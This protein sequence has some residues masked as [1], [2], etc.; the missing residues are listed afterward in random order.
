VVFYS[1]LFVQLPEGVLSLPIKSDDD[2]TMQSPF[3]REYKRLQ[4]HEDY[5]PSTSPTRKQSPFDFKKGA[6]VPVSTI[7]ELRSAVLDQ[8][9]ELRQVQIERFAQEQTLPIQNHDVLQLMAQRFQNH[10][11]PS[12]RG[13]DTATLALAMEGGGMR[14]CVSAGMAA[15]IASLGLTDT[16]DVIYGASAGSV[17]GSYMVSRQM[18]MDVYVD[19]LPAA[20]KLFVCKQRMFQ[21]LAASLVDVLVS[22]RTKGKSSPPPGMNISY[23]LDGIMGQDHGIRPL[24]L[25]KFEQNNAKQPLRVVSSCIDAKGHLFSKCFGTS[26]FDDATTTVVAG[27][28]P[29]QGLFACL[30]AGMTVPGATGAPVDFVN[31]TTREPYSCFDAFCF[32]PIPYR[33]AVQEGATHVLVLCSR[34][35]GFQPKTKPGVY[36]QGVAPLYFY[37]HGHDKV[38]QFFEQGGQQYVYAEDLLLLE[39]GKTNQRVLVPPPEILYGIPRTEKMQ[40]SIDKRHQDWSQA[41]LL[42]LKVPLGTPELDVLEQDKDAVLH[43][44]R[45]GF[46]VAFD[47][48]APIVGL[49][50][51]AITGDQVAQLVFPDDDADEDDPMVSLL[52]TKVHVPGETISEAPMPVRKLTTTSFGLDASKKEQLSHTLLTSLPGFQD[53][54]FGHLAKGLRYGSNSLQRQKSNLS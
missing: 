54:R 29:R 21:S 40:E 44:V 16:I 25:P 4:N 45:A 13:N 34:P 50:P 20:K 24:D 23:V 43:A 2:K 38:A 35:E 41:Y 9:L 53:G 49:D 17:I 52:E 28:R 51:K 26:D 7:D 11:T 46:S 1:W 47:L 42:P 32:E 22:G 19:I 31:T 15:A 39:E 36:E 18:C 14:G 5:P 30:Q 33:S 10:S 37:S 48:L 12:N 8:R 27:G 3:N 6:Q